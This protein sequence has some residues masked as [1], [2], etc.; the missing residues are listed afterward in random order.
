M[1]EHCFSRLAVVEVG[2][3]QHRD[4]AAALLHQP[5]RVLDEAQRRAPALAVGRIGDDASDTER[6]LRRREEVV[7]QVARVAGEAVLVQPPGDGA[8][9]ARRLPQDRREPD[10][11]DERVSDPGRGLIEV[12]GLAIVAGV[13]LAHGKVSRE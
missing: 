5:H 1:I 12:V 7:G 10:R 8:R 4:H 11:H 13:A 3:Q 6:R 2:L 9:P